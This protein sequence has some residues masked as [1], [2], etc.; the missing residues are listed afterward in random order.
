M[1]T[2]SP[3]PDE[4]RPEVRAS[5]LA[6]T[7]LGLITRTQARHC[8]LTDAAI[9]YRL[10]TVWTRV[11]NG[12]FLLPGFPESWQQRVMALCLRREGEVFASHSTAGALLVLDGC[13][14]RP[15][16][17][18]A[19]SVWKAGA[20]VHIHRTGALPPCDLTRVGAI[21]CT[22]ASRTLLDLGATCH[23]D[24]VELALECAL[25][26]GMTSIARLRWRL[27][28]VGGRGR[29][30]TAVLSRL[31]DL[32]DPALRP[33]QSVLEVRFLQRLRRARVEAPVRQFPVKAEG[34]I[35]FLDFAWPE[36]MLAVEVGGRHAH[37]GPAAEQKDSRRHN[38]L[39]HRGWRILYFTW[40]DVE[41]RADYVIGCV[42]TELADRR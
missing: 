29:P 13:R 25:H 42:R 19:R 36:K 28:Q 37:A 24:E 26:R 16:H 7:Q 15:I 18:L 6:G 17:L 31:L 14:P 30:G 20:E 11:D 39:T 8:G 4:V 33:A 35:R 5:R 3:K 21:P 2:P 1:A 40:D 9:A 38:E 22:D 34:R 27:Q 23:P 10:K 12:V 41:H 32:R